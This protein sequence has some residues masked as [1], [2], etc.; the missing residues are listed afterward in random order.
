VTR[1]EFSGVRRS[2]GNDPEI[3][4][5]RGVDLVI[6]Q[7]EYLAIQGP[8][9]S[10]KSTLLNQLTLVDTP[11]G[12]TYLVDGGPASNLSESRRAKLRSDL[13]GF[14]F[15]RFHLMP[16]RTA[17]DN[18]EVGLLY[19]GVHRSQRRRLAEEALD[20]VGLS[21]RRDVLARNL[22]GGEQQRV[23]IA[24]AM[25]GHAPVLVADEPTG[26]LD[27]ATGL[28]VVKH[29]GALNAR[30]TT[31]V[32]VTHD[33]E[34]A[35]HARRHVM[36]RDGRIISDSADPAEAGA[37]EPTSPLASAAVESGSAR[38]RSSK[39][40]LADVARESWHA[41]LGRMGRTVLL[42]MGVAVAV[43]LILSTL[44]LSE[45]A[46]AQVSSSFDLQRN[47][48]VTV[49]VPTVSSGS[50]A[51]PTV[52]SGV[53]SDVEGRLARVA[54][55]Q[56]SGVLEQHDPVPVSIPGVMTADKL[57]LDGISPG[58]LRSVDATTVWMP[59]HVHTLGPHEVLI[60]GLAAQQ[61]ALG[62]LALGPTITLAGADWAVV[63]IV[64]QSRR[65]PENLATIMID[66]KF[67]A[68]LSLLNGS[69]V[70]IDSAGGAAQQIARQAPLAIDPFNPDQLQVQAPPD[71]RTLRATI[72]G[73]VR[74]AL[75]AL[76][77]VASFASLLGVANAMLLSVI[78]RTGELGLR[79]AIG[80]R[81]VHV[82]GQTAA[83]AAVA[84]LVGGLVGLLGAFATVLVV[85]VAQHW[86]PVLDL[87]IAP[88]AVVGGMLVGVIGGLP[89]A[90]RASRI[91]PAEALRV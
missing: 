67:A 69:K 3:H 89:A 41:L 6:E 74:A 54:G 81:P 77:I 13:F 4:A 19:R 82:L 20:E 12:G 61:I 33:G 79:R 57:T 68:E 32:I 45:T 9:G 71:P 88:I 62:P 66:W 80:A 21:H 59:G 18:V 73:N 42:I 34:V 51:K 30:G 28:S 2:F 64:T 48:D 22:S 38:G 27:S 1:L 55:V 91:Q 46:S 65:T 52:V 24:R 8:S 78:E 72:Q 83:E 31:V 5:L 49:T 29:L 85:T 25:L 50:D 90:I 16:H 15:Q 40:R 43:G 63:G 86:Q 35:Q 87:R 76:T 56:S 75:L 26:N 84:G 23:A 60:G 11:S 70:F 10:G 14:V 17:R 36:L 7:G 58:L 39:L 44:S 47:R 53:P 37:G